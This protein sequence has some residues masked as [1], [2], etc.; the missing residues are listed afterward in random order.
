[1]KLS[2]PT[3][4]KLERFAIPNLTLYLATGQG[5][6]LVLGLAQPSFLETLILVPDQALA[7]QWWRLFT[8]MFTPP[9]G[10]PFLAIFT[11][12]LF[13]FMGTALEAHWG[14]LRYNLYLLIALALTVAAAFLFPF[15]PATNI[16]IDGSVF[17]AFAQLYPDYQILLFF[18]LPVRI[19]WLALL[20]WIFYAWQLASGFWPTRLAVLA[21]TLNFLLFFGQDIA[22]RVRHGHRK[23][24][25]QASAI[26]QRNQPRH[27]C[28]VC[29]ITDKTHPTMDFRYCS[30]CEPPVAYCTE[31][32][33]NH[34]HRTA[35]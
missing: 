32:L 20:T 15:Y 4:R 9:G 26:A 21:A 28:A 24:R 35:T 12:Y 19:K 25:Q 29:G 33:R 10:N 5:I 27:V 1:M 34:E 2:K 11:L 3:E 8:F 18:V 13:Y 31:H 7:G 14:K 22:Y 16:Y 6:A 30:K 23:M 17:L